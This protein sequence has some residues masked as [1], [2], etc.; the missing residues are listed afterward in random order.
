MSVTKL[1]GW[2]FAPLLMLLASCTTVPGTNISSNTFLLPS[3]LVKPELPVEATLI[4]LTPS[5]VSSLTPE[6]LD[7]APTW[8]Q[9]AAEEYEYQIG[10]G[11]VLSIVVWD[12]PELTAPFG[13]FNNVEDQGNVVR[14]DGSIFYPFVGDLS[15]QGK[16][17]RDVK[18]S[19]QLNWRTLSSH[20]SLMFASLHIVA[21]DFSSQ[22]WWRNPA[23]SPSLTCLCAL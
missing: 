11:D 18:K 9:S 17:A 7:T 19:W 23:R 16:T 13:S 4:K 21:R 12:H 2:F 3:E 5:I 14:E 10:V 20:R 22:G 8:I 1:I 6:N 15:V